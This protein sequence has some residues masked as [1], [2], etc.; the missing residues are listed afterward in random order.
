M[1]FEQIIPAVIAFITGGALVEVVRQ[2]NQRY[3]TKAQSEE[4]LS[5]AWERLANS[6]ARQ[7]ENSRRLEEEVAS[8][9]PLVLKLALQEQDIKQCHEDKEDWKRYAKKLAKQLEEASIIP[10]PFK[11]YPSD[12]SGKMEAI[13]TN[14][15][16]K[17]GS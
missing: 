1:T 16:K 5:E 10:L 8:L 9:R 7:L 6:Y 4:I 14:G 15:E 13:M 12:D 17:D 2:W 3:V 11:R